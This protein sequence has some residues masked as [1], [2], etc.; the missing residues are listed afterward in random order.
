M[1]ILWNLKDKERY[2]PEVLLHFVLCSSQSNTHNVNPCLRLPFFSLLCRG[3]IRCS[4]LYRFPVNNADS[5]E[6]YICTFI[7]NPIPKCFHHR[8]PN[9]LYI[10]ISL[11]FFSVFHYLDILDLI[12]VNVHFLVNL[13]DIP[14]IC[15]LNLAPVEVQFGFLV[16]TCRDTSRSSIINTTVA[17]S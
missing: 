16:L 11:C 14:K 5:Q 2:S 6:L 4:V 9:H 15:H 8:H 3:I 1:C 17:S 10:T 13:F 7:E 12:V